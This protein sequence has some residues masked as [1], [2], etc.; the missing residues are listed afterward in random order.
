ME[1]LYNV[2][3]ENKRRDQPNHKLWKIRDYKSDGFET[4]RNFR[5]I[6]L[7]L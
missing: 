5:N 3:V 6:P 1:K 7:L 2:I 4:K